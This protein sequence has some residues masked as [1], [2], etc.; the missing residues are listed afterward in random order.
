RGYLYIAKPPLYR[1]IRGRK[2]RYVADDAD[3]QEFLLEQGIQDKVY[4]QSGKAGSMTADR[5]Q[6][7]IRSI[8]RVNG[9]VVR[10]AQRLDKRVLQ[11]LMEGDKITDATM[12]NKEK[13]EAI[14]TSLV[15]TFNRTARPDEVLKWRIHEDQEQGSCWAQ[16]E[17]R[18][19]GRTQISRLDRDLVATVE[20]TEAQKLCSN[21]QAMVEEGAYI[22]GGNDKRWEIGHYNDI[23]DL[24][25][26]EGRR[27]L[28][29]QRYKGLGEMNPE[30]LWETTLDPV[31]RTFLKVMLEDVVSA[32]ETFS[33]L[34]GDAVEPRRNF[35][36]SNALKVRNLDV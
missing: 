22:T 8:F 11:L 5:L 12:R 30:Q 13:L 29:I 28:T 17:R 1:V 2:D 27:G 16:F 10:L 14:L 21:A 19:H 15:E 32:D 24:I 31:N 7:F 6:T 26:K 4:H 9:L 18:D 25:D 34:M 20:F 23:A 35:I 3:L 36:Q 33:T